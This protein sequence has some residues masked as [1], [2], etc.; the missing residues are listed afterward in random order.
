MIVIGFTDTNGNFNLPVTASGW[1]MDTDSQGLPFY[2]YLSLQHEDRLTVDTTT[3]SVSGVTN[4]L[5]KGT[6]LFYGTVK[7]DQ[8]NPLPGLNLYADDDANQYEGCATTDTNGY[9][10]IAVLTEG[11]DVQP[12]N[13]SPGYG[14]YIF[15]DIH[16]NITAGQAVRLDFTGIKGATVSGRVSARRRS[17]EWGQGSGGRHHFR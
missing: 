1:Q 11:W 13:S 8:G 7:D 4:A 5:P 3:G 12:D 9:Y 10:V 16:T 14:S 2:G 17:D 15:P 6:A